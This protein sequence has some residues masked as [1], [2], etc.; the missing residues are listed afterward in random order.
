MA[1]VIVGIFA[2]STAAK[3]YVFVVVR[4]G[5][6]PLAFMSFVTA[7][8]ILEG[9]LTSAPAQRPKEREEP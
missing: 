2:A 1:G 6:V 3:T 4:G 5:G 9:P 8:R 7:N